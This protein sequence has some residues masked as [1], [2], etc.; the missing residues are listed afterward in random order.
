[1]PG[2]GLERERRRR[3]AVAVARHHGDDVVP[4]LLQ[5]TRHLDGLVGADAAADAEGDQ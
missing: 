4:L 5:P 1:M 3:I 2:D